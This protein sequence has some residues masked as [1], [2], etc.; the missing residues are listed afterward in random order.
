MQPSRRTIDHLLVWGTVGA[1][2]SPLASQ[3]AG[4]DSSAIYSEAL[5]EAVKASWD[6]G[7]M[8]VPYAP[9]QREGGW[10][11]S[12]GPPRFVLAPGLDDPNAVTYLIGVLHN[13][14]GWAAADLGFAVEP[15]WAAGK[16]R[17]PIV[18]RRIEA[19]QR[20][21][22]KDA[23]RF[24]HCARCYAAL[25][26]GA[27][28]D[29]RAFEPLLQL[30]QTQR[31]HPSEPGF[32]SPLEDKYP[33]WWYA[34]E[35]LGRLGDDRAVQPLLEALQ[36]KPSAV[37]IYAIARFRDSRTILP[38]LA[39][40]DADPKVDEYVN[41]ALHH[42][43]RVRFRRLGGGGKMK[44]A[45]FPE[46]GG[47][48]SRGRDNRK[49]WRR[50]LEVGRDRAEARFSQR[51]GDYARLRRE[52]PEKT[53]AIKS[54]VSAIT[55]WGLAALPLMMEKIAEGDTSLVPLVSELVD[56]KVAP[57]A[58]QAQCLA[59]WQANKER[60]LIPFDKP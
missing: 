17:T 43:L 24:N 46:L 18:E 19:W 52:S 48:L 44:I 1:L 56:G 35:G 59:W 34:A 39:A 2:L 36:R 33:L 32:E 5:K 50:F 30:L 47:D 42:I 23:A 45:E 20:A 41:S 10:W 53:K 27:I 37:C 12:K 29:H 40:A 14:P 28:G 6:K 31:E 13:G 49:V 7:G 4:N 16:R 25:A 38:L 51:Y 3:A 55:R 9:W 26:L 60:W 21:R 15:A 8:F 57:D 11:V 22:E 58:T 54:Q